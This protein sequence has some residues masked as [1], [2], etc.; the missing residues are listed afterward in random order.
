MKLDFIFQ[1]GE[2]LVRNKKK[3]FLGLIFY[4]KKWKCWVWEQQEQIIMSDDCL[5]QIV[6]KLKELNKK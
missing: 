3:E 2:Y 4:F 1:T 6:S 5:E